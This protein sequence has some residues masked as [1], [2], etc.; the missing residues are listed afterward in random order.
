M[1]KA[2]NTH[3]QGE[4]EKW[5]ERDREEK[6]VPVPVPCALTEDV[7]ATELTSGEDVQHFEFTSSPRWGALTLTCLAVC[8]CYLDSLLLAFYLFGPDRM[9][10]TVNWIAIFRKVNHPVRIS[11]WGGQTSHLSSNVSS[12]PQDN[13]R[14]PAMTSFNV[15]QVTSKQQH[16]PT[17]CNQVSVMPH[18]ISKLRFIQY[19]VPENE[20]HQEREL[21]LRRI[22]L[23]EWN[24]QYWSKI[25]QEFIEVILS[26]CNV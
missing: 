12:H 25:N 18:P 16:H 21:R 15:T 4:S 8:L 3:S 11:L 22:E 5:N 2:S 6:D 26:G 1:E 23:Q 9:P 10:R 19:A 17:S 7:V 20:S 24:H 14:A 13:P